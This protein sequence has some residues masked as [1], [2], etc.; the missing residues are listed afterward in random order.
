MEQIRR[1]TAL[2]LAHLRETMHGS[3]ATVLRTEGGWY[4]VLQMPRTRSE[5]EWTLKLLGES[6]VLVQPGFFF[7]FDAEAFLVV[8]LLPEFAIFTEGISRLR[9]II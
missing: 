9:S 7:D 8:S 2:N 3:S 1:R 4:G 6:D 5:E